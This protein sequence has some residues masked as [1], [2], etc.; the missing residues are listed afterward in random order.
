MKSSL[1]T[2]AAVVALAAAAQ[3]ASASVEYATHLFGDIIDPDNAYIDINNDGI[4]DFEVLNGNLL[5]GIYYPSVGTTNLVA[6]NGSSQLLNLDFGDIVDIS[7]TYQSYG[8]ID[9]AGPSVIGLGLWIDDSLHF[10]WLQFVIDGGDLI[11]QDGA[12]ES[13]ANTGIEIVASVPEPTTVAAGIALLAGTVTLLRRRS[14]R[15]AA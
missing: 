6:T 8:Y 15:H 2:L 3:T 7:Y 10:G 13:L 12:W 1:G 5:M 9:L 11:I 4:A 14:K